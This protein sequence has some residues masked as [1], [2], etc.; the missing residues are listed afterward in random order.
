MG[1][2]SADNSEYGKA[3]RRVL[4][5]AE[6]LLV[7]G[8]KA[9]V[10]ALGNEDIIAYDRNQNHKNW[11]R[12]RP[13][14]LTTFRCIEVMDTL[15]VDDLPN[16]LSKENLIDLVK[17]VWTHPKNNH[18]HKL[19]ILTGSALLEIINRIDYDYSKKKIII[20]FINKELKEYWNKELNPYLILC[21]KTA[22]DK[23][24]KLEQDEVDKLT[25]YVFD[26]LAYH[27]SADWIRVDLVKLMSAC[28]LLSVKPEELKPETITAIR[29]SAELVLSRIGIPLDIRT[30]RPQA[31]VG[32]RPFYSAKWE[33]LMLVT[34]LPLYLLPLEVPQ[35][36]DLIMRLDDTFID[37]SAGM[38]G[39]T[40]ASAR[41]YPEPMTWVTAFNVLLLARVE[42]VLRFSYTEWVLR[43][44]E[45]LDN[46]C[47]ERF[48][49]GSIDSK[50]TDWDDL[51]ETVEGAKT[52]LEEKLLP[53]MEEP[54]IP[55]KHTLFLFGPPGTAKTTMVKGIA[56]SLKRKLMKSSIKEES[57]PLLTINPANILQ[58][59]GFEGISTA[60]YDV[61]QTVRQLSE[62]VVFLDE[63]E[64]YVFER[65]TE[66]ETRQD[67]L[68]TAAMLP[69]LS[70]I[71]NDSILLVMATNDPNNIDSA[72]RRRGRF[73]LRLGI[74]P[75]SDEG[76]NAL[77]RRLISEDCKPTERQIK[78]V[79]SSTQDRTIGEVL[80]LVRTLNKQ[81]WRK[82]NKRDLKAILGKP[83]IDKDLLRKHVEN[84]RAYHDG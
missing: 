6:V 78:D 34:Q 29:R 65:N 10:D 30:P 23:E 18:F 83:E 49:N 60:L 68:I 39:W 79:V 32:D 50:V 52:A 22:L 24:N 4:S 33:E 57:W 31:F 15:G 44:M 58:R 2:I 28:L 9:L 63:A 55:K 47:V 53:S 1:D 7:R 5:R 46:A 70:G 43:E 67:R 20:D 45:K 59:F 42:R 13:F 64:N 19:N 76:R 25:H 26:Q 38:N 36:H 3:T 81:N 69:M 12:S 62:V 17:T 74:G 71:A 16:A 41:G 73:D 35:L 80:E 84:I 11:N 8:H 27:S 72:I 54:S 14:A 37:Q 75:P 51:V 61:F 77:I 48:E 56:F 82:I 40:A 66:G 21:G